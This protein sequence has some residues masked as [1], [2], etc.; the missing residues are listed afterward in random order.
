MTDGD[1]DSGGD[2]DDD[3]GEDEV[4]VDVEWNGMTDID[5][6]VCESAASRG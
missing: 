6:Y 4:D 1:G 5:A 2:S 3:A